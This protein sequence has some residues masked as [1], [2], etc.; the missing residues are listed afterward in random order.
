MPRFYQQI[1][2]ETG[3]FKELG[4]KIIQRLKA[5]QAF[6]EVETVQ[7]LSQILINIPIKEYQLIAQYYFVWCQYRES[8]YDTGALE[9]VIEQTLTYKT[10]AL[11]SRGAVEWY[12]GRPEAALS[13]YKEALKTRCSVSEYIDLSRSIAVLKATEGFHKS[14]LK[15]LENLLRIVRYAEPLAYYETL[16]SYAVE[17]A[18]AGRKG[19]ARNISRLVLASPFAY[20]YPEWQETVQELK[21]ANRAFIS[22]PP[23]KLE[24]DKVKQPARTETKSELLA[25]VLS[26]PQLTVAPL[27]KKP[28]KLTP[29]EYSELT[30][31]D[32]KE[33]ILAALG[34]GAISDDDFYRLIVMLGLVKIGPADKILDLEDDEVLDDIAILWSVQIGAEEFVGF[35]SALRDCDDSFRQRDILDRLICKIFH[36]TQQCGITEDEWRLRVE[37]RLP[38]K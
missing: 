23:M 12:R 35:L 2:N 10:K 17:L 5:A 14:A 9:R 28:A 30:A 4:G 6:R 21:E 8:K 15:D 24:P 7:E 32:K 18:E 13:F 27:P 36:E 26:F 11:F 20:A 3:S 25:K 33:L 34:S 31:S 38:K 1:L 37:R 19:E 16:N 29:H 22:V